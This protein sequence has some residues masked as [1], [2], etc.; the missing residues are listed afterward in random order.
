MTPPT[1][2][3]LLLTKFVKPDGDFKNRSIKDRHLG[4][5]NIDVTNATAA[6]G[7]FT[8]IQMSSADASGS[9]WTASDTEGHGFWAAEVVDPASIFSTFC[10]DGS[11]GAI[12][13][14][15]NRNVTDVDD[16]LPGTA[17]IQA[18]D[19]NLNGN[20]LTVDTTFLYIGC[21]GTCT[22]DGII[23]ADGAGGIG[24]TAAAKSGENAQQGVLDIVSMTATSPNVSCALSGPAGGGGGADIGGDGGSG[25]GACGPGGWGGQ[26]PLDLKH[27]SGDDAVRNTKFI[28][29]YKRGDEGHQAYVFAASFCGGGGGGATGGA[30]GNGG[31]VIYIE[32]DTLVFT[33]TMTSDGDN[34]I[35][36]VGQHQA[37]SGGGG[38]G[39]IIVR[40]NTISSESGTMTITGGT[41]GMTGHSLSAG[42][43]GDGADGYADIIEVG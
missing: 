14:T 20:T 41:K 15:A 25:G 19:F 28:T 42:N 7:T 30:G 17:I 34:G 8:E 39:L 31:G 43:G 27:E 6:S 33:G 22:I 4:V 3:E 24:G 35:S 40:C 2:A 36:G 16:G 18:T 9:V 1:K 13:L 11:D 21:T 23:D 29:A 5:N 10:G 12:T 37:G 32:C 38:G 26:G